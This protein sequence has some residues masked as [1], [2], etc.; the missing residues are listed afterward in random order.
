MLGFH[1]IG[2][3]HTKFCF[4]FR[5]RHLTEESPD[6]RVEDALRP[7]FGIFGR[8][9]DEIPIVFSLSADVQFGISDDV[10]FNARAMASLSLEMP[11]FEFN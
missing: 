7:G 5:P 6:K 9:D 3:C 10:A 8:F 4:G 1:V 2:S 11:L